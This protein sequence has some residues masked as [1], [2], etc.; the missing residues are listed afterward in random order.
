[1]KKDK[2]KALII[3]PGPD[4]DWT[5]VNMT[6]LTEDGKWK[7]G[8]NYITSIEDVVELADKKGVPIMTIKTLRKKYTSYGKRNF[9]N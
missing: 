3:Q 5:I 1:M 7:I 8:L 4:N 6:E 2:I 9:R